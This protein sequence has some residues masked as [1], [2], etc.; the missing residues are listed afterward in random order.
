MWSLEEYKNLHFDWEQHN[1]PVGPN[2][3][4]NVAT[5]LDLDLV[6]ILC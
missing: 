3:T 2:I 5:C 6:V 4:T 1:R